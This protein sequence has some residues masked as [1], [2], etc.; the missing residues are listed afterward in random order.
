LRLLTESL[1]L[2]GAKLIHPTRLAISGVS[3]GP[4]LFEMMEVLG[5]TTVVRRLRKAADLIRED[6]KS[7]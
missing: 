4:G 2:S 6:L 7:E 5:R 3:G 1:D